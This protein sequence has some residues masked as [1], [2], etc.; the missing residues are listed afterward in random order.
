MVNGRSRR[1]TPSR[2]SRGGITLQKIGKDDFFAF[3][4]K[5]LKPGTMGIFGSNGQL[6]LGVF[7]SARKKAPSKRRLRTGRRL[8]KK[9]KLT[10]TRSKGRSARRSL[11]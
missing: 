8:G 2:V 3:R 5:K 11:K 6:R 9:R 7:R 1:K 10:K 4:G